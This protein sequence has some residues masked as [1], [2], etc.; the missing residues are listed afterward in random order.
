MNREADSDSNTIRVSI[1]TKTTIPIGDFCRG[2][3]SRGTK[4]IKALDHDMQPKEKVIP[5]GLL[6]TQTNRPF[7]FFTE[8]NKT[9]D[10]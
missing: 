9:S 5:G 2:G 1:D 6:E 10:F 8:N 4:A 7:L 3:K